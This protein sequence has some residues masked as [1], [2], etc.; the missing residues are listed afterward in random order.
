[1]NDGRPKGPRAQAKAATRARIVA[2]AR[3]IFTLT[4]YEQATLRDICQATG[5]TMGAITNQFVDK[6]EIW[7][8]AMDCEPPGDSALTRAAAPMLAAL[9]DL[10]ALRH[11]QAAGASPDLG[12]R[13]AAAWAAAE[14][15]IVRAEGDMGGGG[16]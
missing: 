9:K 1:M 3:S 8:A 14:A 4:P 13:T 16:S 2:A 12:T 10:V 15:A 6:A 5:L 7:R 11:D